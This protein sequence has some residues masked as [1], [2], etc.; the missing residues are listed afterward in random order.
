MRGFGGGP[1][2]SL[3]APP[4]K[5]VELTKELTEEVAAVEFAQR[6]DALAEAVLRSL[7]LEHRR[8]HVD[9]EHVSSHRAEVK[10]TVVLLELSNKRQKNPLK[11]RETETVPSPNPSCSCFLSS[12]QNLEF[13]FCLSCT[14]LRLLLCAFT[15][16]FAPYSVECL[17]V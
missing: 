15:P 8:L 17:A 4:Q 5:V 12:L 14:A 2:G 10:V 6:G 7:H 13:S 3:D 16:K 9:G 1:Q 11:V